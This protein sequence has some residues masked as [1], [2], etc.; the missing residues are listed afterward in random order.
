MHITLS[1]L[2]ILN[3]I[4]FIIVYIIPYKHSGFII[5]TLW[6]FYS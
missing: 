5:V 3:L 1:Q 4:F 2:L 6:C